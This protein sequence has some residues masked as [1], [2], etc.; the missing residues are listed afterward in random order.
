MLGALGT[1]VQKNARNI[2]VWKSLECKDLLLSA[3]IN[4]NT[5]NSF[6]IDRFANELLLPLTVI[7]CDFYLGV[8]IYGTALCKTLEPIY[9]EKSLI[10]FQE[11]SL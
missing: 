1:K 6:T 4:D 7:Y 10:C 3:Q 8:T 9:K 11:V 5:Q 2:K